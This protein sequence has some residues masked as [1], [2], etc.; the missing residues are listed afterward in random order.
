MSD[1]TLV[2]LGSGRPEA[3]GI[4]ADR[5]IEESLGHANSDGD[6]IF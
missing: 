5:Y 1:E 3:E 4:G 6:F 2:T